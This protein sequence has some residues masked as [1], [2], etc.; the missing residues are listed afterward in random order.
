MR[1]HKTSENQIK[2]INFYEKIHNNTAIENYVLGISM[3]NII[4]F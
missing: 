4:D 3:N 2:N 1:S